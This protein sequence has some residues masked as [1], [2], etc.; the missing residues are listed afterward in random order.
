MKIDKIDKIDKSKQN[1]SIETSTE[2]H[3]QVDEEFNNG[4]NK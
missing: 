3:S 2:F 4:P 1:Y